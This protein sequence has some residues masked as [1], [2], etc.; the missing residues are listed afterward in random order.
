MKLLIFI[1]LYVAVVNSMVVHKAPTLTSNEPTK[2]NKYKRAKSTSFI[3]GESYIVFDK[4]M[5][6]LN[7]DWV[8]DGWN[9]K[10]DAVKIIDGTI[11]VDMPAGAGFAISSRSLDSQYGE[12]TF[13]YKLSVT[14]STTKLNLL[15]YEGD[16]PDKYIYLQTYLYSVINIYLICCTSYE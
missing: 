7:E 15:T 6:T 12:L 5:E 1:S 14:D 16:N 9:L 8:S 13:E 11:Q 3:D 2:I 4:T 10:E